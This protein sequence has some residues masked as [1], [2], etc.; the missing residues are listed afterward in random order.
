LFI[1]AHCFQNK[2]ERSITPAG[3]VA[4][5]LGKFNLNV[6]DEYGSKRVL[7]WDIILHPDWNFN[8]EKFNADI[9]VVVL[10]KIVLFSRQIQSV[11]LPQPSLEEVTGNGFVVGW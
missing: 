9:A 10:D 8:E 5:L 2:G 6:T 3:Y 4:A 11:C 1:A 7:V